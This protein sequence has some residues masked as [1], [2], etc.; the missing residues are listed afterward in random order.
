MARAAKAKLDLRSFQQELTTRLASKTAAQ[1]QSSRLGLAC[2]GERWLIR[3]GDAG[4]VITLPTVVS[5][6]LTRPWF[7]GVSN[8]RGNLYSVVDFSAFL[9]R[10]PA[11]LSG[12]T[13]LILFA[14]RT[15]DLNAGIVVNR[16]LGLRNV[17]EL[18]PGAPAAEAP[19]WYDQRW[20]DGDGNAWQEIDLARLAR[21]PAFLQVGA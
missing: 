13:R 1:V 10:E 5:V 8:I 7:L 11:P 12:M 3:L 18:A 6:P 16:V 21:D 4:E 14:S 15:G 9:G 20:M 17:A 19:A 2:A